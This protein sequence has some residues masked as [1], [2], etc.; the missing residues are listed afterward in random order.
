MANEFIETLNQRTELLRVKFYSLEARE[1]ILVMSLGVLGVFALLYALVWLPISQSAEQAK[2]KYEIKQ[3][4]IAWIRANES[5]FKSADSVAAGGSTVANRKGQSV[6]SLVTDS[7]KRYQLE[8]KR[9]EPTK[10]QGGLRVWLD[11]VPFN[12][13][14]TWIHTLENNYGII[15][16]DIKLE[17]QASGKVNATVVLQG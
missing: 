10:K 4:L 7:S 5:A 14:L 11:D 15:P 17:R 8:F 6:V 16:S 13:I 12:S 3:Q 1:R 9:L 2:R